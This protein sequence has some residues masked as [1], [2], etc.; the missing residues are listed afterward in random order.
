VSGLSHGRSDSFTSAYAGATS[1]GV[2]FPNTVA[3]FSPNAGETMAETRTRVSCQ[4]DCAALEPTLDVVYAD[5]WTNPSVRAPDAPFAYQY[6]N[7][8]TTPPTPL[9]CMTAWTSSCRSTIHYERNIHP[10]WSLLRQTTDAM[11][12][13][14]TDHTCARGGCHAPVDA[15][16]ATAVPAAQLD[17]TDGLS[18]DEADHFNAYRE[19]LFDD[20]AQQVVGGALQDTGVTVGA[21][22]SAVGANAS[23]AFFSRF[24]AGATHAGYLTPDELKLISEWLDVGAQYYNDPFLAPVN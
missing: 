6:A 14:I 12:N 22:M 15:M 13:V 20:I 1:T 5:V 16:N 23:N 19:L 24:D 4:T 21:S 17:L 8:T 7:L 18:P 10:L 3:T 9:G 11:G 2:P